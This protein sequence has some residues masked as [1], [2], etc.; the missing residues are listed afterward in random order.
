MCPLPDTRFRWSDACR[1]RFARNASVLIQANCPDGEACSS[2]VGLICRRHMARRRPRIASF[3]PRKT[4]PAEK[5]ESRKERGARGN[6]YGGVDRGQ[7][8]PRHAR[9]RTASR[10]AEHAA[11]VTKS[12]CP[13]WHAPYSGEYSSTLA[14]V[15]KETGA[16]GER[17][18]SGCRV[19]AIGTLSGGSRGHDAER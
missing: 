6:V 8:G 11:G 17:W 13:A 12:P 18:R 1:V 16:G 5:T 2:R 14:A 9:S 7:R 3:S 19:V 15:C 4:T 10:P